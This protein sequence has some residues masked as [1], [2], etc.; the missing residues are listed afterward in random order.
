VLVILQLGS[1]VHKAFGKLLSL[2]E[3]LEGEILCTDRLDECMGHQ[4]TYTYTVEAPVRL[5]LLSI[6]L[7]VTHHAFYEDYSA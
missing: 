4:A 6:L 1:K 5:V 3:V 7:N 2:S